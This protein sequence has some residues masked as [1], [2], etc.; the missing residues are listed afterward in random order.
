[1][2]FTHQD[3]SKT[4][5][6]KILFQGLLSLEIILLSQSVKTII[7]RV[8]FIERYRM[9]SW[10]YSTCFE[11]NNASAPIATISAYRNRF[12]WHSL[13]DLLRN[14]EGVPSLPFLF[15]IGSVQITN[16]E[17]ECGAMHWKKKRIIRVLYVMQ[18][19]AR[20]SSL[21]ET[22]PKFNVYYI[23]GSIDPAP[24]PLVMLPF[25]VLLL[26]LAQLFGS[27]PSLPLVRFTHL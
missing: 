5:N 14:Y 24:S 11:M 22:R 17:L 3:V 13:W 4:K 27:G 6:Y 2:K 7:H 25:H 10:T 21:R 20:E 15:N 26:H 8:V 12:K 16:K 1:M 9:S 18:C 23:S 19:H